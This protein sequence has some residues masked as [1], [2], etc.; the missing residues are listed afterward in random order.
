MQQTFVQMGTSNYSSVVIF[1]VR[2]YGFWA[3]RTRTYKSYNKY[4]FA[5]K[6]IKGIFLRLEFVL[7][8]NLIQFTKTS[9][10]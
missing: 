7:I 10:R 9:V 3:I 4:N 6:S 2:I 5:K 8:A 1:L